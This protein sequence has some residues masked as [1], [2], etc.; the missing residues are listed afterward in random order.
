MTS[1][2]EVRQYR[3]SEDK[4]F[5]YSTWLRNY[6]HS[7]YFAKRVKPAVFFRGHQAIIDH[8]SRKPTFRVLVACNK[9]DP[10][11]ILGYLACERFDAGNPTVHFVYV[12]GAFRKMGIARQLFET[13]SIS[14]DECSFTH[15]TLP[16]DDFIRRWPNM[17]YDPYRL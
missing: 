16:V 13:A 5:V 11:Q 3:P 2:I 8:L 6:K 14:L 1:A 15:W 9:E 12:K 17:T 7:S 10:T 4:E